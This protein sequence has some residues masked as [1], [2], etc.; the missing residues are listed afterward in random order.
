MPAVESFSIVGDTPPW[1]VTA[2]DTFITGAL[3]RV[4]RGGGIT[5]RFQ[6]SICPW[7]ERNALGGTPSEVQ[8]VMDPRLRLVHFTGCG[9]PYLVALFIG[10]DAAKRQAI[11]M[12]HL[13]WCEHFACECQAGHLTA[14]FLQAVEDLWGDAEDPDPRTLREL[15]HLG[16]LDRF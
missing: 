9:R 12:A 8:E 3:G 16:E 15:L 6:M 1:T 5:E 13:P 4:E 7:G 10:A 11:A 14:T 2:V